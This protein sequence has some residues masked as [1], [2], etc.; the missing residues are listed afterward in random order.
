MILIES[1]KKKIQIVREKIY[2]VSKNIQITNN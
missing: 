1:F 2:K